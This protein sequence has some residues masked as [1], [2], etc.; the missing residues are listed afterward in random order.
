[1]KRPFLYF[2]LAL[3]GIAPAAL[4]DPSAEDQVK[5]A[6]KVTAAP[7]RPSLGAVVFKLSGGT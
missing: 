7:C 6:I 5:E 1:M 4:A 2:L 3:I